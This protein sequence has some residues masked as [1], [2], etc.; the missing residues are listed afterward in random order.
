VDTKVGFGPNLRL[1]TTTV[2]IRGS[3]RSA[4]ATTWGLSAA[5]CRPIVTNV[6]ESSDFAPSSGDVAGEFGASGHAVDT[7]VGIGQVIRVP[8]ATNVEMHRRLTGHALES[9]HHVG[10]HRLSGG[11]YASNAFAT[12]CLRLSAA[13]VVCRL[14]RLSSWWLPARLVTS[15]T[16]SWPSSAGEACC[17][18]EGFDVAAR[19][20]SFFTSG[21]SSTNAR[22][23]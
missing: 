16:S 5:Y 23:A 13:A 17:D 22:M 2:G 15:R 18:R 12:G 20:R 10:A 6:S 19:L 9:R 11:R 14:H 21:H 7:K 4:M 1:P 3:C 8:T